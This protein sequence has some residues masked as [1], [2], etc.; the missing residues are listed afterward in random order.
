MQ[1][2]KTT[3]LGGVIFLI[4]FVIV[5][6]VLGKAHKIMMLVAEPMS[7]IALRAC[8]DEISSGCRNSKVRRRWFDQLGNMSAIGVRSH[9]HFDVRL[10]AL[11]L[12]EN[13]TSKA[14]HLA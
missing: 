2:I 12:R 6:A 11:W 1:F 9:S 13:D 4:P 8:G 14:Q 10:A 5:I 3:I 7:N